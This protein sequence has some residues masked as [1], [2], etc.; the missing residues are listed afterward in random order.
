MSTLEI[1]ISAAV[2]AVVYA[3]VI[4]G[5]N[6]PVLCHWYAWLELWRYAGGWRS[7]IASPIGGCEKCTA[8]Q[9]ALWS[10]VAIR[11]I[12]GYEDMLAHAAAASLAVLFAPFI[13]HA[14]RWMQR[15]I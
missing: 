1:S 6:V 3:V 10:S 4:A 14:Y 11:S 12:D 13:A 9:I 15:R 7:V 5:E 2:V 8:G